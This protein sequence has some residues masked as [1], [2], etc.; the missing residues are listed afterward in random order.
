MDIINHINHAQFPTMRQSD[1]VTIRSTMTVTATRHN[2][3]TFHSAIYVIRN[4]NSNVK[5]TK[6][7]T[8]RDNTKRKRKC[9]QR[10]FVKLSKMFRFVAVNP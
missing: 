2:Q 9:A 7:E 1:Q 4:E 10:K 3:S 8:K 5:S 6:A